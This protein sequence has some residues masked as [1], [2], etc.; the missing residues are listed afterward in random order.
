[1]TEPSLPPHLPWAEWVTMVIGRAQLAPDAE[2]HVVRGLAGWEPTPAQVVTLEGALPTLDPRHARAALATALRLAADAG[3]VYR[4]SSALLGVV[5]LA[6]GAP[7]EVAS[8]ADDGVDDPDGVGIRTV[9]DASPAAVEPT[10]WIGGATVPMPEAVPDLVDAHD[11]LMGLVDHPAL[12]PRVARLGR[13]VLTGAVTDRRLARELAR[14]AQRVAGLA[15]GVLDVDARGRLFVGGRAVYWRRS[16]RAGRTDVC[17]ASLA[18]RAGRTILAIALGA[19]PA[20]VPAEVSSQ[21]RVA[22]ARLN[23]RLT[24]SLRL[25]PALR[26]SERAVRAWRL[27]NSDLPAEEPRRRRET[28]ARS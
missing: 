7:I 11:V 14:L 18:T 27:L 1:M 26:P 12:L 28:R 16:R 5:A 4:A 9:L 19:P 8:A 22:L 20:T 21:A 23:V 25:E 6:I 15:P 10:R 13:D 24:R 3:G 2:R 17:R